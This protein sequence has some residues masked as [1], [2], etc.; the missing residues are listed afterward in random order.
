MKYNIKPNEHF[1]I[2]KSSSSINVDEISGNFFINITYTSGT[3]TMDKTY[4]EVKNA[5]LNGYTM[6]AILS[7]EYY[8]LAYVADVSTSNP[9]FIFDCIDTVNENF[10]EII[11]TSSSISREQTL[12]A[13]M[14]DIADKEDK[15]VIAQL[16]PTYDA[17]NNFTGY[18]INET[19]QNLRNAI[20]A[21]KRVILQETTRYN[22]YLYY[23]GNQGSTIIFMSLPG[24]DMKQLKITYVR[25]TVRYEDLPIEWNCGD[26]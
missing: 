8:P 9:T 1:T 26:Y 13:T 21:G 14:S 18:T 19:A 16:S 7:Y 6:W 2:N 5:Y 23:Y 12:V 10:S 17:N 24:D 20:T 25:N 11:I 3:Y 22:C 4:A 15:A